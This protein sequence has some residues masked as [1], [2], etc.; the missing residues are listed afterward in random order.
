MYASRELILSPILSLNN[1]HV[2][3]PSIEFLLLCLSTLLL[4]AAGYIINDY[5]DTK[6][7]RILR[8]D[9][10]IVGRKI[11]RRTAIK[12]HTILN[13]IAIVLAIY[14]SYSIS[15]AKL[16]IFFILA[17]GLLWFY[18]TSYKSYVILG[19][20]VISSMIASMPIIVLL[21]EVPL[22]NIRYAA[23]MQEVGIGFEYL[24][25]WIGGLSIFLFLSSLIITLTKDSIKRSI[26]EGKTI[27]LSVKFTISISYIALI[28]FI[29][30]L[31]IRIFDIAVFARYY[32]LA[33]ILLPSLFSMYR[34]LSNSS[35]LVLRINYTLGKIICLSGILFC[36][37][38]PYIIKNNLL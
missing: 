26:I 25:D 13:I 10:T 5:F 36:L 3:L 16:S 31:G 35:L 15:Y 27:S 38:I 14:V 4:I 23:F 37:F 22:L 24:F 34:L 20:I 2:Q 21:F 32:L 12:L 33:F 6:D 18:S 28:V 8:P 19:K 7:D 29:L 9:D 17:S 11:T 30:F 1:H